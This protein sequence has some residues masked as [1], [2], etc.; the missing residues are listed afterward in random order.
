VEVRVVRPLRTI[1]ILIAVLHSLLYVGLYPMLTGGFVIYWYPYWSPTVAMAYV[2]GG[3]LLQ[4]LFCYR[5]GST[6]TG[7]SL[8]AQIL[9]GLGYLAVIW[10]VSDGPYS[11]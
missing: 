10:F 7:Q 8:A 3:I 1:G 5:R 6:V 2:A 11:S 4:G 9:T